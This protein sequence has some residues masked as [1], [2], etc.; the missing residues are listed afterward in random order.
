MAGCVWNDFGSAGKIQVYKYLK[1]FMQN[2]H[3]CVQYCQNDFQF[4]CI[5]HF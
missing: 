3:E 1:L 5:F 2:H 4:V